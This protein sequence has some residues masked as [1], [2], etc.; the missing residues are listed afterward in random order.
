MSELDPQIH[1]SVPTH[2]GHAVFDGPSSDPAAESLRERLYQLT[3]FPPAAWPD[4]PEGEPTCD[5]EEVCGPNPNPLEDID[6][7]PLPDDVHRDHDGN[8]LT[9]GSRVKVR[10]EI[11][12]TPYAYRG[13]AGTVVEFDQN[14]PK[15]HIRVSFDDEGGCLYFDGDELETIHRDDG[16]SKPEFRWDD[17]CVLTIDGYVDSY[18]SG[19]CAFEK[20]DR[21]TIGYLKDDVVGSV[22][23]VR[24]DGTG[25]FVH[26]DCLRLAH[27]PYYQTGDRVKINDWP[28][29][30]IGTS[31][32]HHV[33]RELAGAYG[34][35]TGMDVDR[36]NDYLVEFDHCGA[37][38][39]A[40][41]S[42][43]PADHA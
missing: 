23:A 1:L 42:M 40:P 26:P 6:D 29:Y 15:C 22:R 30:R 17:E 27:R 21:V 5:P 39:I 38:R 33:R 9:N 43:M 28:F 41:D 3:G 2:E 37:D 24:D 7:D 20:G 12:G 35:V 36:D 34:T 19:Y 4:G 10:H 14:K 32:Q 11:P 13:C 25:Q 18:G 16:E 8:P 31:V